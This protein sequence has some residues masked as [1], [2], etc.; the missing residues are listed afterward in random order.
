LGWVGSKADP[1][2]FLDEYEHRL[3]L[4]CWEA[5]EDLIHEQAVFVFSEGTYRGQAEIEGAFRRTFQTIDDE[6]YAIHDVEWVAVTEGMAVCAYEYRWQGMI[7]GRRTRGG[8][9][10]TTVLLRVGEDWQIVHEHLGPYP[11]GA[12]RQME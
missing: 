4:R 5:L 9:R 1:A 3:A 8:D 12:K 7:D 6:Q 11:I 10:G 2:A